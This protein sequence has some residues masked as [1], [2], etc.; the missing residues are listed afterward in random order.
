MYN[1][2]NESAAYLILL[3]SNQHECQFLFAST[4]LGYYHDVERGVNIP[5]AAVLPSDQV[6]KMFFPTHFDVNFAQ[7]VMLSAPSNPFFKSA[8]DLNLHRR[9]VGGYDIL[10]K[11]PY[12]YLRAVTDVLMS[13]AEGFDRATEKQMQI[14]REIINQTPYA[15]SL[16]ETD[17][18]ELLKRPKEELDELE[19]A[20]FAVVQRHKSGVG[21]ISEFYS[22]SGVKHWAGRYD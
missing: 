18:V 15:I 2:S 16:K 7:D 6:T 12:A 13:P 10:N 11:G 20:G 9:R 17:K 19:A 1:N 4:H 21:G 5:F 3:L 8:I 14:L 22:K